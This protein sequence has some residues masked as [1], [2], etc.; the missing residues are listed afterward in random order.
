MLSGCSHSAEVE[1]S[2]NT[3]AVQAQGVLADAREAGADDSQIAI[4]EEAIAA[5]SVTYEADERAMEAAFACFDT[6]GVQYDR[7]DDRN[8][9]GF[10]T[11]QYTY[12]VSETDPDGEQKLSQAQ[13]CITKFSDFVSM[14]YQTQP[15]AVEAQEAVFAEARPALIACLEENDMEINEDASDEDLIDRAFELMAVS[16]E[17]GNPIDCIDTAGL[18]G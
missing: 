18:N 5:G 15:A 14:L 12:Y 13:A 3:F 4:L 11:P 6:V 9:Q 17:A 10:P 2:P 7:G 16:I 1:P 8:A